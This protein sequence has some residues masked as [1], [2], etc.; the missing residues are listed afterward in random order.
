MTDGGLPWRLSPTSIDRWRQCPRRFRYQDIERR[1]FEQVKTFEQTLGEVVHKV[2][3][4]LFRL[5]PSRREEEAVERLLD[6][7]VLRFAA[8]PALRKGN[9]ER[10]RDEARRQ[11]LGV[12]ASGTPGMGTLK[13]EQTFQLRLKNGTTIQTRVDR[14]DRAESGLLHVIDYKTG[15]QQIDERDLGRETA[16]I[17]QLLAV[18]KASEIPVEKVTWLYLRSSETIAWWPEPDDVDWAT[19][20]L[21]D[22]LREI[23][24]DREFE[25]NPGV[26]C[27]SC[28]FTAICPAW[29]V[30]HGAPVE[31]CTWSAVEPRPQLCGSRQG[32]HQ[33]TARKDRAR[34]MVAER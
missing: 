15:R 10:L 22:V 33:R 18:G 6:S 28:P 3:E 26:H 11:L 23:H 5:E 7:I 24:R 8:L 13:V 4:G 17:V 32:R 12:I 1:K 9:A 29:S 2:L 21:T 16:P 30:A 19:D 31:P 27:T 20:R 25:P 34:P 14:I